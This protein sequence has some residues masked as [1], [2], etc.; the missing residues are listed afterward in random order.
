VTQEEYRILNPPLKARLFDIG[1]WDARW[2]DNLVVI[3]GKK[4]ELV[5]EHTKQNKCPMLGPNGCTAAV[6]PIIC[7][8]FPFW[9]LKDEGVILDRDMDFVCP[10]TGSMTRQEIFLAVNETEKSI[11]DKVELFYWHHEN[12][13][14]VQWRRAKIIELL[15]SQEP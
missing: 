11:K 12:K 14:E 1:S 3:G 6:K 15:A 7:Q 2:E 5:V 8:A 4:F 9:Y 13:Q 10:M